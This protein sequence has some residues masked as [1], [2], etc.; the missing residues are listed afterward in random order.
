MFDLL[1]RT[2]AVTVNVANVASSADVGNTGQPVTASQAPLPTVTVS[3]SNDVTLSAVVSPVSHRSTR[4]QRESI[5]HYMPALTSREAQSRPLCDSRSLALHN[6]ISFAWLFLGWLFDRVDLIKP[7]SNARSYVRAYLR[8]STKSFFDFSEIW[9]VGR[10][11]MHDGM[12]YDPIQGSGSRSR[13]PQSCKSGHFQQLSPPPFTKG[14]GNW[15]RILKLGLSIY[16]W[17]GQIFYVCSSFCVKVGRNVSCEES[18][19]SHVR[20]G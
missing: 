20:M 7:V 3:S 10:W 2:S 9:H 4:H 17:S 8:L 19:I 5:L 16:V 6:F 12:Q 14:A 15:P 18:T 11:P 1:S 13:A